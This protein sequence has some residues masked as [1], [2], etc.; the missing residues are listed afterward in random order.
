MAPQVIATSVAPIRASAARTF[1]SISSLSGQAGVVSS[2]VKATRL[3]SIATVLDHVQGHDVAAELGLL[4]GAEGGEDRR[5][6]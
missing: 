5:P 1:R 6:R 3:P 4:D 2:I